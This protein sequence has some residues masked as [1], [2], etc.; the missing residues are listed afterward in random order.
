MLYTGTGN[1]ISFF[2]VDSNYGDNSATDTLTINI[3]QT[4]L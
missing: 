2:Y 1:P 3:F 4:P